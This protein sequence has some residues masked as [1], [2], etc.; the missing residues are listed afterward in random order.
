M[1]TNKYIGRIAS[2][3]GNDGYA[4]IGIHSVTLD[5][6]NPHGLETTADIF[7]HKDECG[8]ALRVGLKLTFAVIE[9]T[10]RGIGHYRATEAV[11]FVDEVELI[12]V[13]EQPM[14]GFNE[15]AP[16]GGSASME[17]VIVPPASGQQHAK[18]ADPATLA[19]VHTNNP[20]AGIPRD[21][22]IPEDMDLLMKAF[23]QHLFPSLLEFATHFRLDAEESELDA[24]MEEVR[25][26]H[27]EMGMQE[28]LAVMEEELQRFKSFR[29]ALG[30]LVNEKL[31]RR[32]TIVPIRYLPDF[33][34]A[35]P[36]WYCWMDEANTK[37]ATRSKLEGDPTIHPITVY[38]CDLF[39][40]PNWI[41][42]F[43]IYNR[44]MRTLADYKGD[45][46]PPS[47]LRRIKEVR[48]LFDQVVIMTPYH[49]VAGQDWQDI[50]WIRSIDPYVVGFKKGVPY[51][52]IIARFSD[53]GTF[54]LFSELV[55]D[56][57]SFLRTNE[58]KLVG[59]NRANNPYWYDMR[60]NPSN[61]FG[62]NPNAQSAKL[63]DHL[64]I[65][66]AEA[67]AAFDKGKLFDWLRGESL[68]DQLP[69]GS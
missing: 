1:Q 39:P 7:L 45:V 11:E 67:L 27:I 25:R 5:N 60:R 24:Q 9:D 42:M 29:K 47:V 69:E 15:L 10:A 48:H 61:S 4:F 41:D 55:A 28:Q 36:V 21:S 30:F 13:G 37:D 2:V 16:F 26:D 6:G 52:F 35:V 23:L 22:S 65:Q 20:A 43:Q 38:F 44:R 19:L 46:I 53:S 57:I 3:P 66:V 51:F 34:C 40:N 49:D 63:G 8:C 68:I 14:Q 12:P 32:D 18:K 64:R 33:F 56:T 59:F 58:D 17:L 31:V 50:R 54:P 62:R